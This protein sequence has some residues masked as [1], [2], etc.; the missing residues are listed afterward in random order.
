MDKLRVGILGATGIVGQS[1]IQLLENHPWFKVS[2]LA[3]SE[4]SSGKSYKEAVE[5]RW[6]MSSKLSTEIEDLQVYSTSEVLIAQ[7]NCDF[8]FSALSGSETARTEEMYA[9]H[10]LPVV[11]NASAHRKTANVPMII[12]EINPEHLNIIPE[13]QKQNG[14]KKG[15]IVVKPNC[16]IQSYLTPLFA[17]NQKSFVEKVVVTT[18]QAV[19]GAGYPGVSSMDSVDNVVPYINGEEEKSEIEPLKILGSIQEGSIIPSSKP[20]I[21]AHCNRV[22]VLDGHLATVSFKLSTPLTQRE[23][24]DLWGEFKG[25]PQKKNLPF[26]PQQAIHYF[27]T[28]DRPQPR[29][30]RHL[31]KGMATC[32]GRLR[33]CNVFDF[34]F[35]GLSHN[36][37]RGAAGGGIL[38]AE[39]LKSEGYL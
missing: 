12:P 35:V 29:K 34:R 5:G 1:Y 24:L 38:N 31:D 14:W 7:K 23:I 11:S 15:F 10:D 27:D 33:P 3:A 30:D 9:A 36:T 32:I 8:V 2:F 6:H 4:R 22:P 20:I 17:I 18:M 39:L 16:S 26:S 37:I 21:S 25:L 19:S 28:P 13:Q